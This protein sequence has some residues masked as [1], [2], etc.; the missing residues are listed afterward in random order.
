MT[1][2][3]RR[4]LYVS[5]DGALEALGD[6]QVVA[7][8]ERLAEG[9][10]ITLMTFEK[11]ADLARGADVARMRERLARTG[12]RWMPLRYHKRPPIVS[13]A[14]D[15]LRGFGCGCIWALRGPRGIVHA[16]SYVPAL[17]AL[18][19]RK[20]LG[21]RFLFDMRG[22]WV[23]ERIDGGHWKSGSAIY[24][25]AKRCERQFFQRADAIVSLTHEGVR[26]FAAL[27]YD[28]A[29][30]TPIEV[31]PTCTDLARFS[32]GPKNPSLVSRLGLS[33]RRV[34]GTIGTLSN[35]YL[36]DATLNAFAR[37]AMGL[38]DV[39]ILMVTGEDHQRLRADAIAAGVPAEQLVLVRAPFAE[40]P[41]YVRLMDL[42]MFFIKPRFSKKGTSATKLG[43]FLGCGVPVVINEGVGDSDRIIRDARAGIVLPNPAEAAIAGALGDVERLL[44]DPDAAGRCREAAVQYFNLE[45]G[46]AR[47]A[48]LYDELLAEPAAAASQA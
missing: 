45:E 38:P 18:W 4:V 14:Y 10:E 13:T 23:D 47:Y 29:G 12:I 30:D 43:E 39:T 2:A 35:W 21:A 34:V 20:W 5:Y 44:G 32:P 7:Y 37:V 9:R 33:G 46:V 3:A 28:I 1:A 17:I 22:F 25:I 41:E 36:R 15:L 27:G 16:R 11:P 6:S 24:R 31:I 42:G 26:A 19:L 40:M 8:L 48:R